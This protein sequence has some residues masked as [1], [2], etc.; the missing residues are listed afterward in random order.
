MRDPYSIGPEKARRSS[1]Y[2]SSWTRLR[3]IRA[4]LLSSA[5]WEEREKISDPAFDRSPR[6][7]RPR[8][9]AEN[10]RGV[11]HLLPLVL[12]G[13]DRLE[14]ARVSLAPAAPEEL[15]VDAAGL[16][17]LRRDHVKPAALRDPRP[18][19]DVGSPAG[20]VR[21]DR[22]VPRLTG[23]GHDPGLM[24][25]LA[26]VQYLVRQPPR[27]EQPAQVLGSRHR[28]GSDQHGSAAPMEMVDTLDDGLP[29]GAL[30]REEPGPASVPP[31]R[32]PGRNREGM[33]AVH[34]PE[35]ASHLAR[36]AEENE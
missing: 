22:D 2:S 12:E 8:R 34:G 31:H 6:P 33:Q 26:S 15:A 11:I 7:R 21:G 10:P 28:A 14:A 23:L 13:E 25:I 19:P 5:R 29:L 27:R 35:L 16:V 20:H 4:C 9:Q 3:L 24:S 32:P 36:F 17:A 30:R 1:K 18:Q